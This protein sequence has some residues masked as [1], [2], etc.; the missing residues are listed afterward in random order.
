MGEA[1]RRLF[2]I[3]DL[4]NV[5]RDLRRRH[6]TLDG[7]Q[8]NGLTTE[9]YNRNRA[10]DA[11]DRTLETLE[12]N[13]AYS[14]H[15]ANS[16]AANAREAATYGQK[17]FGKM[18]D[19]A[20]IAKFLGHRDPKGAQAYNDFMYK[21]ATPDA[22]G[23]L[24]IADQRTTGWAAASSASWFLSN[25]ELERGITSRNANNIKINMNLM[26]GGLRDYFE[27]EGLKEY[28]GDEEIER[29]M[30][31]ITVA[32]DGWNVNPLNFDESFDAFGLMDSPDL[33]ALRYT[34]S[35]FSADTYL[36]EIQEINP[37]F[38][39]LMNKSGVDMDVLKQTGN[40]NEFWWNVNRGIAMLG[41]ANTI[42]HWK[43]TVPEY[44]EWAMMA[45]D[46]VRDSLMN[47]PDFAGELVIGG[48][49]A[50]STGPVGI[51]ALTGLKV[52]KHVGKGKKFARTLV[53]AARTMRKAAQKANNALP[54]NWGLS[55]GYGLRKTA[56][57][58]FLNVT[59]DDFIVDGMKFGTTRK[60]GS[61]LT[62]YMM[63]ELPA[64]FV[65]EGIAGAYNAYSMNQTQVGRDQ[66]LFKAFIDEGVAGSLVRA[67]G[68]NPAL[69]SIN[70]GMRYTGAKAEKYLVD[71]F[72]SMFDEDADGMG[73]TRNIG[74]FF[75]RAKQITSLDDTTFLSNELDALDVMIA[76]DELNM[77]EAEAIAEIEG[78]NVQE[79]V[80]KHPALQAIATMLEFDKEGNIIGRETLTDGKKGELK[81]VKLIRKTREDIARQKLGIDR[82]E[83]FTEQ[84][85][86]T[87]DV[88]KFKA[89]QREKIAK[90]VKEGTVSKDEFNLALMGAVWGKLD[91]E[92]KSA[93]E[94]RAHRDAAYFQ[95]SLRSLALE[96]HQEMKKTNPKATFQEAF[97]AVLD[98]PD[99]LIKM[100]QGG[101]SR[102]IDQIIAEQH[103][104]L[105]E[106][107]TDE[108]SGEEYFVPKKDTEDRKYSEELAKHR[109]NVD[110]DT[111]LAAIKAHRK[112]LGIVKDMRFAI[113]DALQEKANTAFRELNNKIN[114]EASFNT[115]VEFIEAND[116]GST[117]IID[118]GKGLIEDLNDADIIEV[119]VNMRG[120][121]MPMR[122]SVRRPKAF[123]RKGRGQTLKTVKVEVQAL[124]VEKYDSVREMLNKLQIV[125]GIDEVK[126]AEKLRPLIK[127]AIADR[128]GIK[129]ASDTD[130][131]AMFTGLR[132]AQ[133]RELTEAE[134]D[135]IKGLKSDSKKNR[136]RKINSRTA[137]IDLIQN[138]LTEV[139]V[140]Q[141]SVQYFDG[142]G[143]DSSNVLARLSDPEASRFILTIENARKEA[144]DNLAL[145]EVLSG[146]GGMFN[147][148]IVPDADPRAIAERDLIRQKDAAKVK[149]MNLKGK[150]LTA[151]LDRLGLKKSGNAKAKKERV[152]QAYARLLEEGKPIDGKPEA[153]AKP[154]EPA[155]EPTAEETEITEIE[156]RLAEIAKMEAESKE[157]N[158]ELAVHIIEEKERLT[159]RLNELKEKQPETEDEGRGITFDP[160]D[161][162]RPGVDQE[163]NDLMNKFLQEATDPT[164]PRGSIE[165]S[166]DR[167]VALKKMKDGKV[168]DEKESDAIDALIREETERLERRK[169]EQVEE[170]SPV[171][172][173]VLQAVEESMDE[174]AKT[175]DAKTGDA[176]DQANK[177]ADSGE[178][179]AEDGTV[180]EDGKKAAAIRTERQANTD[181]AVDSQRKAEDA[182]T[183]S[184]RVKENYNTRRPIILQELRSIEAERERLRE[185]AREQEGEKF[186][187]EDFATRKDVVKLDQREAKLKKELATMEEALGN[188]SQR[189]AEKNK[190]ALQKAQV[191]EEELK[192]REN[193]LAPDMDQSIAENV[194]AQIEVRRMK[195]DKA[196]DARRILRKLKEKN[197][198]PT[199]EEMHAALLEVGFSEFDAKTIANFM[200]EEVNGAIE[201]DKKLSKKEK[202]RKKLTNIRERGDTTINQDHF[203]TAYE[204]FKK[205]LKTEAEGEL[206]QRELRQAK[207][208][209]LYGKEEWERVR[210]ASNPDI[211][212]DI[213]LEGNDAIVPIRGKPFTGLINTAFDPVDR[214]GI[215]MSDDDKTAVL[216]ANNQL[217]LIKALERAIN[218]LATI[219][220]RTTIT[221]AELASFALAVGKRK[222]FDVNVGQLFA[223]MNW[224]VIFR[225]SMVTG[226]D[227]GVEYF[228]PESLLDELMMHK[229]RLEYKTRGRKTKLR[230]LEAQKESLSR[231]E[232]LQDE[233][234]LLEETLEIAE[235]DSDTLK[236]LGRILFRS[237]T[238]SLRGQ[239]LVG[240]DPTSRKL[241]RTSNK[242]EYEATVLGAIEERMKLYF[243]QPRKLAKIVNFLVEEGLLD[244]SY[245]DNTSPDQTAQKM[246]VQAVA[247]YLRTYP[248]NKS[249][250]LSSWGNGDISYSFA[251]QIGMG[252]VDTLAGEQIGTTHEMVEDYEDDYDSSGAKIHGSDRMDPVKHRGA[253]IKINMAEPMLPG[254]LEK[255]KE[256]HRLMMVNQFIMELDL[257][258]EEM[259]MIFDFTDPEKTPDKTAV[260]VVADRS[261]FIAGE[262]PMPRIIFADPTANLQSRKK[263]L[264]DMAFALS[265]LH[266]VL[267]SSIHDSV[268]N[269]V[270]GESIPSGFLDEGIVSEL[271]ERHGIGLPGTTVAI[272]GREDALGRGAGEAGGFGVAGAR[273]GT[274]AYHAARSYGKMY[275]VFRDTAIE[276]LATWSA[277]SKAINEATDIGI[278]SAEEALSKDT[279][280]DGNFNGI[281][282]K[283][284]LSFTFTEMELDWSFPTDK[285]RAAIADKGDALDRFLFDHHEMMGNKFVGRYKNRNKEDYY[286][287]SAHDILLAL[288]KRAYQGTGPEQKLAQDTVE[289]LQE[290]GFLPE[291]LSVATFED[292]IT[293]DN[294]LDGEE[295]A[296]VRALFKKPVMTYLYGAKKDT[297]NKE[298]KNF[299]VD[300][301]GLN[302][303]EASKVSDPLTRIALGFGLKSRQIA[304]TDLTNKDR[305]EDPLLKNILGD[306]S[307]LD[308]ILKAMRTRMDAH[309]FTDDN[310]R[311]LREHIRNMMVD[312]SN[313]MALEDITFNNLAFQIQMRDSMIEGLIQ[314]QLGYQPGTPEYNRMKSKINKTMQAAS[315]KQM[316][317][318]GNRIR[319]GIERLSAP[320]LTSDTPLLKLTDKELETVPKV[321]GILLTKPKS[322]WSQFEEV[323][324]YLDKNGNISDEPVG[325][326]LNLKKNMGSF[327]R[328]IRVEINEGITREE[329]QEVQKEADAAIEPQEGLF[330]AVKAMGEVGRKLDMVALDELMEFAGISV[331][332]PNMRNTLEK[333]YKNNL[334]YRGIGRDGYAG[335]WYGTEH[336]G[337]HQGPKGAQD[338][339]VAAD[340]PLLAMGAMLKAR[341]EVNFD[342]AEQM[343]ARYL[344]HRTANVHTNVEH[345]IVKIAK[346]KL[347]GEKDPDQ[348]RRLKA[349]IAIMTPDN[350][351]TPEQRVERD[352]Q[353]FEDWHSQYEVAKAV[354]DAVKTQGGFESLTDSERQ[355]VKLSSM[356]TQATAAHGMDPETVDTPAT[357]VEELE[358][359][360]INLGQNHGMFATRA[361]AFDTSF[362]NLG[363]PEFKKIRVKR[364]LQGTGMVTGKIESLRDF[365]DNAEESDALMIEQEHVNNLVENPYSTEPNDLLYPELNIAESSDIAMQASRQTIQKYATSLRTKLI[366][367]AYDH[368]LIEMIQRGEWQRVD[369]LMKVRIIRDRNHEQRRTE[370]NRLP[371]ELSR[372]E[373][374]KRREEIIHRYRRKTAREIKLI[375]QRAE[376]NADAVS[377]IVEMAPGG[378]VSTISTGTL[379]NK[380]G[381]S[382]N[383]GEI[384]NTLRNE[385]N[386]LGAYGALS[387][388]EGVAMDDLS[389]AVFVTEETA[390]RP[391]IVHAS[392]AAHILTLIIDMQD[393]ADFLRTEG[394]ELVETIIKRN[395]LDI[396]VEEFTKRLPVYGKY[397]SLDEAIFVIDELDKKETLADRNI[398][399]L[400]KSAYL[401]QLDQ[402]ETETALR[403]TSSRRGLIAGTGEIA[404]ENKIQGTTGRIKL[405]L[406]QARQALLN[407]RNSTTLDLITDTHYTGISHLNKHKSRG[408][409][410]DQIDH[411][412]GQRVSEMRLRDEVHAEGMQYLVDEY[413]VREG[414]PTELNTSLNVVV[415]G[416]DRS[417]LSQTE[418]GNRR[419]PAMGGVFAE[420]P[421][422]KRRGTQQAIYLDYSQFEGETDQLHSGVLKAQLTAW[423]QLEVLP[424]ELESLVDIKPPFRGEKLRL[425][426]QQRVLGYLATHYSISDE[427]RITI[428]AVIKD[429]KVEQKAKSFGSVAVNTALA[430][431]ELYGNTKE[432]FVTEGGVTRSLTLEE[433]IQLPE[434]QRMITKAETWAT[435]ALMVRTGENGKYYDEARGFVMWL[436][437]NPASFTSSDENQLDI[438]FFEYLK[439]RNKSIDLLDKAEM[440]AAQDALRKAISQIEVEDSLQS[441]EVPLTLTVDP[442]TAA[443]NLE[444]TIS[445]VAFKSSLEQAVA[446]G[447]IS[448]T[449]KDIVLAV[450]AKIS[451]SN[452]D[453]LNRVDI[454][455]GANKSRAISAMAGDRYLI[456]LSTADG[457]K[458]PMTAA[459]ILLHELVH[460]GTYKYFD[461]ESTSDEMLQI[462][463]LMRFRSVNK[464]MFDM[465]AAFTKGDRTATFQRHRQFMKKP[466]EF[467]AESAAMFWLTE[468]RA[469]IEQI[470]SDAEG[471]IE[472]SEVEDAGKQ[473][474]I[475]R[476]R[477]AIVRSIDSTRNTLRS[478]IAT[479]TEFESYY[480][481][482]GKAELAK[483]KE[484]ALQ[485]AGI[486]VKN[487][488]PDA[489]LVAKPN[490]HRY[491]FHHDGSESGTTTEKTDDEVLDLLGKIRSIKDQINTQRGKDGN[492]LSPEELSALGDELTAR[493]SEL[494][495]VDALPDEFGTFRSQR[496]IAEQE[497]R[498]NGRFRSGDGVLVVDMKDLLVEKPGVAL[499][500][501]T[502][503]LKNNN[504]KIHRG[505]LDRIALN[506]EGLNQL[507]LGP[508]QND[509]TYD[510]IYDLAVQLS[511]VIDQ[512]I[513]MTEHMINPEGTSDLLRAKQKIDNQLAFLR[514]QIRGNKDIKPEQESKILYYL[515]H[516]KAKPETGEEALHDVAKLMRTQFNDVI[517]LAKDTGLLFKGLDYSPVPIKIN[518][519]ALMENRNEIMK[520]L[521]GDIAKK[522][523]GNMADAIDPI[524]LMSS[525]LLPP[526]F[527]T[528]KRTDPNSLSE[529]QKKDF[530]NAVQK[531]AKT[532]AGRKVIEHAIGLL[533]PEQK[534]Q[535][536]GYPI[537]ELLGY[538]YPVGG[539]SNW[540]T[541][542]VMN[543]MIAF[544]TL[545]EKGFKQQGFRKGAGRHNV[546]IEFV[547][548]KQ[549]RQQYI[550]AVSSQINTN[551]YT[552]MRA[553]KKFNVSAVRATPLDP[554]KS[555]D[556][557]VYSPATYRA[558]LF[559]GEVQSG[560]RFLA[561][562]KVFE[563]TSSEIVSQMLGTAAD[564][565]DGTHTLGDAFVKDSETL[566]EG[567]GTGLGFDAVAT[568]AIGHRAR[569]NGYEIEGI[570]FDD[571]LGALL[572]TGSDA[573]IRDPVLT[574]GV[575]DGLRKNR[576]ISGLRDSLKVV[577]NKYDTLAGRR[578]RVDKTQGSGLINRIASMGS[579]LV[580]ASYG[581][582]LA[583]ATSIVEGT[584]TAFQ[585]A[586]RGDMLRGP[587]MLL[588]SMLMGGAQGTLGGLVKAGRLFGFESNRF[589][590]KSTAAELSYAF[591]H[592]KVRGME[593]SSDDPSLVTEGT[594][595]KI[596]AFVGQVPRSLAD[597]ATGAS[598]G[599]TNGIKF[600]V[601]G[602]AINTLNKLIRSGGLMKMAKFLETDKGK[603]LLALG[604]SE[605]I[606]TSKLYSQVK[607]ILKGSGL[608]DFAFLGKHDVKV[609]MAM[610]DSGVL[611]PDFLKDLNDLI[612]VAGLEQFIFDGSAA[613]YSPRSSALT[614]IAQLQRA[615]LMTQDKAKRDRFMNTLSQIKEYVNR[616]IEARF[617]G[618]NPLMMDTANSAGAILFKIFRS[619]PTLFFGQRLRQ[620]SRYY[621]PLQNGIRIANL[622]SLDMLYMVASAVASGGLDEKR[623]DLLMQEIQQKDALIR[624]I[625]RT[626]TFGMFGGVLASAVA[627]AGIFVTGGKGYTQNLLNQAF[628]PIPLAK[629]QSSGVN[630]LLNMLKYAG[631]HGAQADARFNLALMNLLTSLPVLQEAYTKAAIHH[632]FST[633]MMRNLQNEKLQRKINAGNRRRSGGSGGRGAGSGGRL[634][635]QDPEDYRANPG[636]IEFAADR[637]IW[638]DELISYDMLAV[639]AGEPLPS[640]M[641][642]APLPK[643]EDD[644]TP[645]EAAPPPPPAPEAPQKQVDT[646]PS[647][648]AKTGSPSQRFA[649]S[650]GQFS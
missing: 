546:L 277:F 113:D 387:P 468:A 153:E 602:L 271:Y 328:H 73:W 402:E 1:E 190:D 246:Y 470:L 250:D 90:E 307:Q 29:G 11:Q 255:L 420:G 480:G 431:M 603:E 38:V 239:F 131:V 300:E 303:T 555:T 22:T 126:A 252:I 166:E 105:Y 172:V 320:A 262:R 66:D 315:D 265:G 71:N 85:G 435:T 409:R 394:R 386:N 537:K 148:E 542:H 606:A 42:A 68:I 244:P 531:L 487:G 289:K 461:L 292:G 562:D 376:E 89:E 615:A 406:S 69:R 373:L 275:P 388:V 197:P 512:Q 198:Q 524:T 627:E 283:M 650:L 234:L 563:P 88:R 290:I 98:D 481:E 282:H 645:S 23:N 595:S 241:V 260:G 423:K 144:Q 224:A 317:F 462:K 634:Y 322:E 361:K 216:N 625:A 321:V 464:L 108:N 51:A 500:I 347:E 392:D 103:P 357:T 363:V 118:G 643:A 254:R 280:F 214:N 569:G 504:G 3:E 182:D 466:E 360:K 485:A 585:M 100:D 442:D 638:P 173:E 111:Q 223:K 642:P 186:D 21:I 165:R 553:N 160:A 452:A 598:S 467:V 354:E 340:E 424:D 212:L 264:E 544:E 379:V 527:L 119:T 82:T 636:A 344:L 233:E 181:R 575:R 475:K 194:W 621:G 61:K 167:L 247:Q 43:E 644:P 245:R 162:R 157:N 350:E 48:M 57:G 258:E 327:I 568:L 389:R 55:I 390:D 552:I 345:V 12:R 545:Y 176:I 150:A 571:I 86:D 163:T 384:L 116:D 56:V 314:G 412:T 200:T 24:K 584:A 267:L 256:D 400:A 298:F 91:S 311:K 538:K 102:E 586:G 34:D 583:L 305:T 180:S 572:E 210:A 168:L 107:A 41:A 640:L 372:E 626:P 351:L 341:N 84:E 179:I 439:S 472:F 368:G 548:Q 573:I 208:M 229:A 306:D 15:T 329:A 158:Q 46:F 268:N 92:A 83:D 587:A 156:S 272:P 433:V 6:T 566:I 326:T 356:L 99:L 623:I 193:A 296:K 649:E 313:P 336:E 319:K 624:L 253:P 231:D 516:P 222:G 486:V 169:A 371:A 14:E 101:V 523:R 236:E 54:Q 17:R 482:E 230:A 515:A 505:F 189:I 534:E 53:N 72:G 405:T 117:L 639:L 525:G 196:N 28:R 187:D 145:S 463:E 567:V 114:H 579:D 488:K 609:F 601:E 70:F 511:L 25:A 449:T 74:A 109:R 554:G 574:E 437:E 135:L 263:L 393:T 128:L 121:K 521:T 491:V 518:E 261:K 33:Q 259:G 174:S 87:E 411:V 242:A 278:K 557:P 612:N 339:G 396:T 204:A 75:H 528:S 610:M 427:T 438:Q 276:G 195:K 403:S 94:A 205:R 120:V 459:K 27:G 164:L 291:T 249:G 483:M 607:R 407:I 134:A 358:D 335:R 188:A 323:K 366:R 184:Q 47:D 425:L 414:K 590:I 533:R 641:G 161:A 226:V 151:E 221:S 443:K 501:F 139:A 556:T 536:E 383:L 355:Q 63:A 450:V 248:G 551:Q 159:E 577:Q 385:L 185:E 199:I 26:R 620:D 316:E 228:D 570:R 413:N 593:T 9:D 58:R 243:A 301:M 637:N 440:K 65:E 608:S 404:T 479:M 458:N 561:A 235:G 237:E 281:H 473:N 469:E 453:F 399:T 395:D 560:V 284:A 206:T 408:T 581:G 619:Y 367:F 132:R 622:I 219:E 4:K 286:I 270:Y 445:G 647:L 124:T 52:A 318:L 628:I 374:T 343:F 456:E 266:D 362:R 49:L 80:N 614:H 441:R 517:D 5:T 295:Y 310:Q 140:G 432:M 428:P 18:K 444:N 324:P 434:V 269:Q 183:S 36:N 460:V 201:A 10:M 540:K 558:E 543:L 287:K 618:G 549:N 79:L 604:E 492:D 32:G 293:I 398:L 50:L 62:G 304:L 506:R 122:L 331:G 576:S 112:R 238:S 520:S 421:F 594:M 8:N 539:D 474:F 346:Q 177:D 274:L 522:I 597:A 30:D 115:V 220:G 125:T 133:G 232:H 207:I 333:Y 547:N 465:T 178:I 580:L 59:S 613:K 16:Q 147:I 490:N 76:L 382:K 251:D 370:L 141:L 476:I 422:R 348:I 519:Q 334:T 532:E 530:I 410:L 582:N 578:V 123:E 397:L 77:T 630:G 629:I 416:R 529:D 496:I 299:L 130:L 471:K 44:Q 142:I 40:A 588:K 550:D 213:A 95:M 7:G 240:I 455:F 596:G 202:E 377:T 494:D 13:Y 589:Q 352:I 288:F 294:L 451:A 535:F 507:T 217:A 648:S 592:T 39:S 218:N 635:Y 225:E 509:M 611:R 97:D 338:Q 78:S 617:V 170:E 378:N 211:E 81:L 64:G 137:M 203:N 631:E 302:A 60:Y 364:I 104:D 215:D 96:K 514:G 646:S 526:M 498:D 478:M 279:Y 380:D 2:E 541:H 477:K 391:R 127:Q 227:E 493:N 418:G 559:L 510:S 20:V 312:P 508:S 426:K 146:L 171:E 93:S 175:T 129:D 632:Y 309:G 342:K 45:K 353:F 436:A 513:L 454:Q 415:G 457:K 499:S 448:E 285:L 489:S 401:G 381:T 359:R 429:G 600:A 155:K 138:D 31:S 484:L 297:I 633:P 495:A 417:M 337:T 497:L 152:A 503:N 257:T 447:Y 332:D 565:A 191:K 35:N 564:R 369:Y 591:E 365:M 154:E 430:Y 192:E 273:F 149:A 616:E 106:T 19:N 308:S 502:R 446:D 330:Q 110:F 67:F 37:E 599:V 419:L 349:I 209:A 375:N 605:N 325:E 143:L 136:Q